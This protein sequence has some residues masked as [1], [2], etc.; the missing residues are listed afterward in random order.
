[1]WL[2]SL[3]GT[4]ESLPPGSGDPPPEDGAAES[5]DEAHAVMDALDLE[6]TANLE[7]GGEI[8]TTICQTCHGPNGEGG[9]L[10]VPLSDELTIVDIVTTARSGV[11]GTPMPP[12]GST[13]SI[14]EL[15]DVASYIQTEI[16]S[17][18]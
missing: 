7:R 10:G 8:Y 9:Q 3:G 17:R 6:R 4:I 1:L 14:E 13:Y 12:F 18:R 11:D 2:F 15:H 5:G 16:L